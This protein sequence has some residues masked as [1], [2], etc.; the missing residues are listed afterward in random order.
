MWEDAYMVNKSLTVSMRCCRRGMWADAYM[1]NL[2]AA[3]CF[4]RQS[5]VR[6]TA[7]HFFLDVDDDME[8][9]EEEDAGAP[10]FN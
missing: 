1:V 9:D 4:S 6:V 7:L 5:S 3:A 2:I 10:N 8:H